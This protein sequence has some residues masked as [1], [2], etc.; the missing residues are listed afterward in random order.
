MKRINYFV[1]LFTDKTFMKFVMVGVINTIVGTTIMFVFYNV[2]H[3]SY[4]ISSASNYFFGSICSYILNKHFTFQYHEQGWASL[5]RFTINILI[6][7][8][9]A[10]GIAKP[11]MQW[12]LSDY[13]KTIQENISMLL[14]MCL[15][16]VF[17]YLGQRFF[18]F[19][20]KNN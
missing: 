6:C 14:G 9:L 2:F 4:W 12:I 8:L 17:N 13:S 19:K 1:R 15:F 5:L 3:L 16:I 20:K 7:Y 18:A 10:Y 11:L